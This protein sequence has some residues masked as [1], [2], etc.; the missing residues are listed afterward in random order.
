MIVNL[1][2]LGTDCMQRFI[3]WGEDLRTGLDR[4]LRLLQV[5]YQDQAFLA[6]TKG[7]AYRHLEAATQRIA[8]PLRAAS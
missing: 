6:T 5:G 7:A 8:D 3:V 4:E 1:I 2:K